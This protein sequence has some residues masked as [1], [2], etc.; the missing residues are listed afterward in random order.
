MAGSFRNLDRMALAAPLIA[1]AAA[2][3]TLL[4]LLPRLREYAAH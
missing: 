4:G 1:L 2:L 3:L